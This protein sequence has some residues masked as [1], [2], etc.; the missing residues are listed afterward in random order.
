MKELKEF[1]AW[2][3]RRG[4][5][6]KTVERYCYSVRRRLEGKPVE[7]DR[8]LNAALARYEEFLAERRAE[9]LRRGQRGIFLF[10]WW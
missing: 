7:R 3:R 5:K 8:A 4:Y 9:K 6:E 2:L 10:P 1:A